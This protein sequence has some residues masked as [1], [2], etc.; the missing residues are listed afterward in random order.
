MK[1]YLTRIQ[2]RILVDERPQQW[3]VSSENSAVIGRSTNTTKAGP[4]AETLVTVSQVTLPKLVPPAIGDQVDP[5]SYQQDSQD[6]FRRDGFGQE[7]PTQQDS[8]QRCREVEGADLADRVPPQDPGPGDETES[9]YDRSLIEESRRDRRKM[10]KR[11]VLSPSLSAGKG[12]SVDCVKAPLSDLMGHFRRGCR[13]SRCGYVVAPLLLHP[14][15]QQEERRNAV[16]HLPDRDFECS[17]TPD[18]K[19]GKDHDDP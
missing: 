18:E 2:D 1:H 14:E 6:K 15:A 16:D 9:G 11:T 10:T 8:E 3:A 12:W 19:L 17:Q 4:P 13:L 7:H 5:E